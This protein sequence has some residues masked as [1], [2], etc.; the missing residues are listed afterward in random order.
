MHC[1]YSDIR[2]RLGAPVWYDEAAVPRYCEFHPSRCANI[3]ASE[4]LLLLL[5]CQHCGTEFRVA[6]TRAHEGDLL[7]RRIRARELEY[8]DPPN[9]CCDPGSSMNGEPRAVL[10][11]WA[12]REHRDRKD[13]LTMVWER[14]QQYE[15]DCTPAWVRAR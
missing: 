10:E 7:H 13:R 11:Y 15:I 8:D 1:D 2:D 12:R 4:A 3:Y 6:I 9:A 5:T 14:D